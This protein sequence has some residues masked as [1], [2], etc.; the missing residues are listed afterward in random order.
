MSQ[1]DYAMP[2][3]QVGQ[4]VQWFYHYKG[5][6]E[7]LAALVTK[8]SDRTLS[9]LVF[10]PGFHNG[11][12]KDGVRHVSDP[13]RK[14]LDAAA[15]DDVGCWDFVPRDAELDAVCQQMPKVRSALAHLNTRDPAHL[16]TQK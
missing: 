16:T 12:P 4:T 8:V 3:V 1:K 7:P 11:V 14:A 6:H 5:Q 2:A 13:D 9:L 10:H 15:S